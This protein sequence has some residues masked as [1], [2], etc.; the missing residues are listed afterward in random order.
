MIDSIYRTLDPTICAVA[1]ASVFDPR[2]S[3][4]R[5]RGAP[6]HRMGREWLEPPE[7]YFRGLWEERHPLNTPGPFYGAETDTC[8]DGPPLAPNSLFYDEHG[9]GFVWRQPRDDNETLALMNG[10]SSDP[11]G[12][13]AWDGDD[14]WTTDLVRAWWRERHDRTRAVERAIAMVVNALPEVARNYAEYL[15]NGIDEDLRRYL[16]FLEYGTYPSADDDLPALSP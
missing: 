6:L 10:A 4:Q 2:A 15:V 5:Q 7:A 12:G 16:Y 14:H 3:A 9:I 11:F 1:P 8:L 13:F